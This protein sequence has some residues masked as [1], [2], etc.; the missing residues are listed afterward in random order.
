MRDFES[1][2]IDLLHDRKKRI[3]LI[4]GAVLAVLLIAAILAALLGG[5]GRKYNRYCKE[6]ES[7]Y[8]AGDY[9]AAE[10][11]L[12]RAMELKSNE[13]DYLRMADIY[14]AEGETDRAIQIL[15]LGYSHL[16]SDKIADRL[17][18]LKGQKGT[19][20]PAPQQQSRVTIGKAGRQRRFLACPDGNAPESGRPHG[21]RL[22]YAHGESGD[23][24]LRH[25]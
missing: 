10:E 6:A 2:L 11:K 13:K 14:C 12:R 17:E 8:L 16:G 23:F 20:T 19:V 5:S 3:Y 25:Q 21:D 4:A 15:Y 9:A 22:A 1:M 7:A 24:R 18:E